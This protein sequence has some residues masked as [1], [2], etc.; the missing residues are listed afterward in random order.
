MKR[1]KRCCIE[2]SFLRQLEIN[3]CTCCVLH[4]GNTYKHVYIWVY[5][6]AKCTLFRVFSICLYRMKCFSLY[7]LSGYNYISFFLRLFHRCKRY[8]IATRL[9]YALSSL[10]RNVFA[11]YLSYWSYLIH[12]QNQKELTFHYINYDIPTDIDN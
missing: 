3:C 2:Q 1:E 11:I 7:A 4:K 6:I 5:A 10:S 12:K 9:V 8:R